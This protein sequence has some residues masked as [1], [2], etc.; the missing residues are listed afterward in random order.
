MTVRKNQAKKNW[1][2]RGRMGGG[3]VGEREG[4]WQNRVGEIDVMII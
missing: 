3:W 2:E 1:G 4:R